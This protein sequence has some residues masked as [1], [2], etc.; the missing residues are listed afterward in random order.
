MSTYHSYDDLTL[1]SLLKSSDDAAFT[2]IY[3]RYAEA[4][5]HYAYNI[6]RDEDECTDAIQEVFVWLWN[7]REKL[8]IT[9]LKYY[10]LAAV[11]HK[12]A[13][14][15]RNSKRKTEILAAHP[16][17]QTSFEED[18]LEL[19]ELK[20]VIVQ[21]TNNLPPR[22]KEIFHLS[23]NEYLTNREIAAKMNISEKTVENQMTITLKKLKQ[24]L[25]SFWV[26][27]L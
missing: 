5:Y 24:T 20:A 4:L 21:F 9:E 15:I 12:L 13:R 17:I 27:F 22:A 16:L 19:R 23:R 10:L 2:E 6:L 3:N 8:Q 11:K 7:C 1:L 26:F 14:A 18:S 25:G